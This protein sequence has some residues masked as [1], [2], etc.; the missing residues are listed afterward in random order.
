[1]RNLLLTCVVLYLAASS[2]PLLAQSEAEDDATV[3]YPAAY[4]SEY[5]VVSV[6][7]ML[8]RIPGI[9]L[10]LE[11]NQVPSFGNNNN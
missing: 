5:G 11:G 8:S 7:D 9:D 10:A 6:N 4:F 2:N 1:M 3:Y